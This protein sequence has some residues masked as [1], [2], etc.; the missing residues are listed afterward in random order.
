[1]MKL[2]KYKYYF[3]LSDVVILGLS[4]LLSAYFVTQNSSLGN[5]A[6]SVTAKILLLSSFIITAALIIGIG[7]LSGQKKITAN[8]MHFRTLIK[9]LLCGTIYLTAV[10]FLFKT[11]N[12]FNVGVM[13]SVFSVSSFLL[14]YL[15]RLKIMNNT[16]FTNNFNK[17]ILVL[18]NGKGAQ[19]LAEKKI[20]GINIVGFIDHQIEK[21]EQKK[22][23]NL[24][25]LEELT[26]EKDVDEILISIDE[27]SYPELLDILDHCHQF[28]VEVK[29]TSKLF[30]IVHR[31]VNTEKY[32]DIPVVPLSPTFRDKKIL[33]FKRF[34]DVT[35]SVLGLL[36]LSPFLLVIVALIK[37]T[38]PGPI[39]Y[40]QQ[41]I[42]KDGRKF[43]F[44]KFRSMTVLDGEDEERKEKMLQFMNN[45]NSGSGDTK[46]INDKRVTGVGKILRKT[47]LDELPQLINVIKGDMSLV[48]PRPCLP[49]EYENYKE[50]QKRRAA[51]V[52]GCTGVWQVSGRSSVSFTDSIVLDLYYINNMSVWLD[53]KLILKTIPVMLLAKG[54]K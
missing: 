32:A 18:G 51:V 20:S 16:M 35:G 28:N 23:N 44:Y 14:L 17:N 50:W 36:F 46:I 49:Y 30:E 22:I 11:F 13:F 33:M 31:K 41:R 26:R 45:S 8:T 34:L 42:G 25:S 19:E 38:S 29:I 21:N 9:P 54:G 24:K 53:I 37:L 1:M 6:L 4:F 10:S 5:P 12:A 47:S 27:I 7:I 52:P 43:M 40:K 39:F 48:G 2:P 15:I 3:P